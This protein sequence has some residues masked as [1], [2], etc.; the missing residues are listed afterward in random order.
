MM[1]EKALSS[2]KNVQEMVI[3]EFKEA[4]EWLADKVC[5]RSEHVAV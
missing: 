4:H 3:E 5:T 1:L 2:N